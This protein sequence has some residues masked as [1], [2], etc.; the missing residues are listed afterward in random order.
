MER[1]LKAGLFYGERKLE[2][3]PYLE[4][5]NLKRLQ[6]EMNLKKVAVRQLF[7]ET[8]NEELHKV[9]SV[10]GEIENAFMSSDKKEDTEKGPKN[11]GFVIFKE[12][13]SAF[14]AIMGYTMIRGVVTNN[15]L[16]RLKDVGDEFYLVRG[17]KIF[18]KN[19]VA[20]QLG[21][22]P[23]LPIEDLMDEA[24]FQEAT[25]IRKIL[26]VI[27]Q[28]K[29]AKKPKRKEK[30]QKKAKRG[31]P[32]RNKNRNKKKQGK[33]PNRKRKQPLAPKK[34][35]LSRLPSST[36]T[37]STMVGKNSLVNTESTALHSNLKSLQ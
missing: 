7:A 1:L 3:A 9:F 27:K 21:K 31:H 16:A 17:E 11:Y 2:L 22:A 24:Y 32:K 23:R 29:A 18:A 33:A 26:E 6:K 28:Q 4:H 25:K 37:G 34:P 30:N 20:I 15:R 12:K 35:K 8:T 36:F 13:I 19:L 14:K 5:S 10:F